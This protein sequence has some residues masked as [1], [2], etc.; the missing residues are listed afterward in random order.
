MK[1]VP[2]SSVRLGEAHGGCSKN[3]FSRHIPAPADNDLMAFTSWAW[4]TA[5]VISGPLDVA[6][7]Q[8]FIDQGGSDTSYS[9]G[10]PHRS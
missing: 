8:T 3:A 5:R 1:I 6:L 2:G 9:N 4:L 7:F 10:L